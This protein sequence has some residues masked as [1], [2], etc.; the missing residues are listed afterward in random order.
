MINRE[1]T[2]K[3]LKITGVALVVLV[4]A[5]YALFAS[6][7]FIS[8]PE[9]IIS[10]PA[11]GSVISTSTVVI[12]GTAL[13]IQEI[14]LNGRPIFVDEG[15]NFSETVLLAKG[16]NVSLLS[17]KDKFNRTTEYKLELVYKDK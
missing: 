4:V 14:T 7:N 12:K 17:A 6:N 3:I 10:E 13:R 5:G 16:Y 2:K 1:G 9:I 8:G 11:T 15:G